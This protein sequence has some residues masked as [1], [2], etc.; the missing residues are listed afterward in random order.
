MEPAAG[1]RVPKPA[2]M[3]TL[4]V[5]NGRYWKPRLKSQPS[6]R[7]TLSVNSA[8]LME[9]VSAEVDVIDVDETA[10]LGV[11]WIS[12]HPAS[13]TPGFTKFGWPSVLLVRKSGTGTFVL[14]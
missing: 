7:P 14:D 6:L 8:V 1:I 11:S 2:E 12:A 5:S 13:S 3:M 9:S 10:E 4:S